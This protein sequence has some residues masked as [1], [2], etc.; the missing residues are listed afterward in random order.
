LPNMYVTAKD[1]QSRKDW[2]SK[3]QGLQL[4]ECMDT[5]NPYFDYSVND[6]LLLFSILWGKTDTATGKRLDAL[7]IY[8]GVYGPA[9]DSDTPRGCED[10]FTY[11]FSGG[12]QTGVVKGLPVASDSGYYYNVPP[13]GRFDPN[14]SA[15]PESTVK[16][17]KKIWHDDYLSQLPADNN[18][19]DNLNSA[20]QY[21]DTASVTYLLK[22]LNEMVEEIGCQGASGVR[23]RLVSYPDDMARFRNRLTTHFMLL[24]D[25]GG[26]IDSN[27]PGCGRTFQ[28]KIGNGSGLDT[29]SPCPPAGNC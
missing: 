21:S 26:E 15:T 8:F 24:D 2:F 1:C 10:K 11:I 4:G 20:G 18:D 29:G 16:N 9:T 13:G 23:V 14:G 12:I 17:W 7:T 3:N 19:S 27:P 6:F 22:D 28:P 5:G 25:A